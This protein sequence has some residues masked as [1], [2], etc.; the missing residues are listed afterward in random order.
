MNRGNIKPSSWRPLETSG[1]WRR[2]QASPVN[3][4]VF[5]TRRYN[6]I[7]SNRPSPLYCYCVAR[8]NGDYR[9]IACNVTWML[10]G[11]RGSGFCNNSLLTMVSW[12]SGGRVVRLFFHVRL[13]V[14]PC[15]RLCAGSCWTASPIRQSSGRSV[16]RRMME[17][18]NKL[19]N[20]RRRRRQGSSDHAGRTDGRLRITWAAVSGQLDWPRRRRRCH[21]WVS[22]PSATRT[23]PAMFVYSSPCSLAGWLVCRMSSNGD[24]PLQQVSSI[25]LS[26]RHYSL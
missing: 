8:Y 22:C 9:A 17:I 11:R 26:R 14:R 4:T 21:Y 15:V 5:S 13:S 6:L 24:R 2:Y 1:D 23:D 3:L 12:V 18:R 25:L 19:V 10:F 16:G 7:S 20:W